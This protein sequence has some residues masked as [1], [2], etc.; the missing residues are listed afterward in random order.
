M[1]TKAKKGERKEGAGLDRLNRE[2]L[3]EMS[4]QPRLE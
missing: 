1:L 4:F 3:S 2:G